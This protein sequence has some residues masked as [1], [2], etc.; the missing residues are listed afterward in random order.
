[1]LCMLSFYLEKN[2]PMFNNLEL[3]E[4]WM[5]LEGMAVERTVGFAMNL[6]PLLP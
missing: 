5:I 4:I 6:R 3:F 1:M 2:V